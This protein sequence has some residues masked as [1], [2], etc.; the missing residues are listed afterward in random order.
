MMI[1]FWGSTAILVYTLIGY[2]VIWWIA[3]RLFGRSPKPG[4]VPAMQVTLLVAAH[5]EAGSIADKLSNALLLDRGNL[6][7]KIVVACDGCTDGTANIVRSFEGSGVTVLECKEHLGKTHVMNLAMETISSDIVV[8]SDANSAI[9]TDA[10]LK[11]CRHFS[12]DKVGGVCGAI[13]VNRTKGGWLGLAE[14]IYWKYDHGLKESESRIAG[15]VSAQGSLYAVRRELIGIIPEAMADDLVVSLGVVFRGYRL[16]FDPTARTIE[17][18]SSS[19][20]KEYGR[21]VRSTE[22]GWRGL[23]H[24]SALLNPFKYGLYS[25]QLFSHKVL[26]RLVPFLFCTAWV[27][28]IF[29]AVRADVYLWSAWVFSGFVALA[30]LGLVSQKY[31]PRVLLLPSFLFMAN[32]AMMRGVINAMTGKRTVIWL[33]SREE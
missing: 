15:A 1:L 27:A 6:V 19:R 20:S 13:G 26:R 7:V 18:V 17:S 12:D 28:S 22:R 30:L 8:F 11:L 31:L 23:M 16:V 32:V 25:L 24:F 2:G 5:N 9:Q 33:P 21:R 4:D 10:L 29:L 3:S 14:D